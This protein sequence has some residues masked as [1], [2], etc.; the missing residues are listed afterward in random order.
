[1]SLILKFDINFLEKIDVLTSMLNGG[2][3]KTKTKYIDKINNR[4]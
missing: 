3:K 1:M 2:G 4:K